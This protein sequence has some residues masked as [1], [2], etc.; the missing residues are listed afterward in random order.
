MASHICFLFYRYFSEDIRLEIK[1]VKTV[2]EEEA[3]VIIFNLFGFVVKIIGMSSSKSTG[4]FEKKAFFTLYITTYA[5]MYA[6]FRT[7]TKSVLAWM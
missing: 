7:Y 2:S 5:I 1:N 3:K 4:L 6:Y